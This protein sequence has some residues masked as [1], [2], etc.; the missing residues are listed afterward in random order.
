MPEMDLN[1]G[2]SDAP[3]DDALRGLP[4]TEIE[5]DSEPLVNGRVNLDQRAAQN[6]ATLKVA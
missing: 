5:A 1:E 2:S 3:F 6:V 4:I